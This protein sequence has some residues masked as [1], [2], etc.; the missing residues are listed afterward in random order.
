MAEKKQLKPFVKLLLELGPMLAFFLVFRLSSAEEGLPSSEAELSRMILATSV[1][2]PLT[3][4]SLAV[5]WYLTRSLPRMT[6][7]T[8]LVVVVFGGLTIWLR[9]DTFF[10][11]KPTILY[12]L[13]A[14]ILGFGLL[15]GQSYLQYLLGEAMPMK[16]EGWMIFTRRFALFFI[17]LA[18]V[19]ELVWRNI[20]TETW[21]TF[22]TFVLPF[23]TFGFLI[24]QAPLLNRY[25]EKPEGE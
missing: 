5:S 4:L 25:M 24:S 16:H 11:M 3:I 7:L 9:D 22:R 13:F 1:F 2:I 21:V 17:G 10:K 14:L 15:R 12:T 23:V 20:D 18:V 6:A 19:N 8:A